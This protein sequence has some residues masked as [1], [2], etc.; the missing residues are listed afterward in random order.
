MVL[1]D[2]AL[3]SWNIGILE[4]WNNARLAGWTGHIDLKVKI[5]H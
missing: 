3:L 2:N 5:H 1:Q 4:C